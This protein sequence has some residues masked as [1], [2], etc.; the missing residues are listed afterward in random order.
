MVG[1]VRLFGLVGAGRSELM[2]GLL[3][4]RKSPPVRYIDQQPIDIRKA[5]PRHCRRHDALPE[6]LAEGIIPC[7]PFACISIGAR[8]CEACYAA[9]V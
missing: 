9:V 8:R 3:A 7:T 5:E 6:D 2:K 1:S 4:G